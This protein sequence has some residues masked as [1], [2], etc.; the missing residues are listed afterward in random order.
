MLIR[1]IQGHLGK[2]VWGLVRGLWEEMRAIQD[3][4]ELVQDIHYYS[5]WASYYQRMEIFPMYHGCTYRA[6][7]LTDSLFAMLETTLSEPPS[8][9]R[10]SKHI[11]T[12]EQWD[13]FCAW[14]KRSPPYTGLDPS[15]VRW[16]AVK[17]ERSGRPLPPI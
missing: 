7:Q 17:V 1:F 14:E 13:R 6:D 15:Y 3:R 16:Y 10:D 2:D 4:E 5:L 12:R 11:L 8:K 9:K